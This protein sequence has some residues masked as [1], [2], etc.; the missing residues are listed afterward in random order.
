MTRGV[1]FKIDVL[2]YSST[3]NLTTFLGTYSITLTNSFERKSNGRHMSVKDAA[4]RQHRKIVDDAALRLSQMPRL[5]EGWIKTIRKA[6][7]MSG[8]QLARR[9]GVTRAAVNA[10]EHKERD[11]AITIRKMNELAEAMDCDFIY[12]IVPRGSSED[13]ILA[14][15]RR[16]A[17]KLVRRARGQMALEKQALSESHTQDEIQ[18]VARDMVA[19][20][21]SDFWEDA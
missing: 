6:L 3:Y 9:A 19:D 15:A 13:L 11:G 10:S 8:A 7:G 5:S 14:Q 21:P 16:K 12:A 4:I 17:E 2:L 18:R 20:M 1:N